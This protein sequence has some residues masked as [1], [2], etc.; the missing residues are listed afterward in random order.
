M[1]FYTNLATS[2]EGYDRLIRDMWDKL[3]RGSAGI[4][5]VYRRLFPDDALPS[6]RDLPKHAFLEDPRLITPHFFLADSKITRELD[7]RRAVGHNFR[8]P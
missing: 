4:K 6:N 8:T 1:H 7:T 5:A 2:Q 3:F